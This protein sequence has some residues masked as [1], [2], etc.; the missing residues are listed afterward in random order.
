MRKDFFLA[1]YALIIRKLERSPLSFKELETYLLNSNEFRDNDIKSYS[2][3]T[4]QRD[5]KDIYR[6][7]NIEI[8]NK[9]GGENKYRIESR[10]V[11]EIDEYN[12]QLIESYQIMNAINS[13]PDNSDYVF[14]ESRKTG[15]IEYF[16]DI[17][18]AI[19][20]KKII[21]F[22]YNSFKNNTVSQRKVHPLALKEAKGRWYVV[23]ADSRDKKFK[24]FGLDRI[25]FL[26]VLKTSYRE[27]YKIDLK[28]HFKYDFGI[29][30]I[31]TENPQKIVI[32]CYEEQ[33]KY[34]ESFPLHSSQKTIHEEENLLV[35]ELFLRP[36]YDF[37]QEIMSFGKKVKV[38]EPQCLIDDIKHHFSE[39]LKLYS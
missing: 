23:A 37:L 38:I 6:L 19:R 27:K 39:G 30:N 26:D 8:I 21:E 33:G 12:Q 2:V 7:F 13:Y 11:L 25:R 10:P 28:E 9:K 36:T 34:I 20:N 29:N 14:M 1:R 31:E 16:Y 18:Y 22:E 5:I 17:L 15:G 35:I 24:S 32:E 3:R 4:L